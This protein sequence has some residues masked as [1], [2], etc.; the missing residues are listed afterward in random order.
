MCAMKA[1]D[2]FPF[3]QIIKSSNIYE[4]FPHLF[5]TSHDSHHQTHTILLHIVYSTYILIFLHNYVA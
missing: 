4:D 1:V 3:Y 5:C 2:S